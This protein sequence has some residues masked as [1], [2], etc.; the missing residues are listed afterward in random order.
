VLGGIFVGLVLLAGL[1]LADV[2]ATVFFA[3]TVAYLLA[4]VDRW[5]R[6][7]GLSRRRSSL[8]TAVGAFVGTL[9]LFSPLIV[10]FALR[11]NDLLVA[12]ETLPDMISV[13]L[14]GATYS[15]TTQQAFEAL[16][17]ILQRS[18]RVAV[19]QA[20]ILLAKFALFVFLVFSLLYHQGD[21]RRAVLAVIP[22]H[23][24]SVADSL[25]Q[26][27][28]DTLFAIYVLQ[29][30]T[31]AGTFLIAVPVFVVLGYTFPVTLAFLAAVL[32]FL[33]VVGPSLLL[34]G[35]AAGHVAFGDPVAAILV[36]LIGGFLIAW[37]PD[38]LIRPRLA[39]ETAGLSGSLYF[40]GFV[41]GLLTL[42]PIGI[43]AGPLAVALVA[44]MATLLST[45]LNRVSVSE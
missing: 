29:A 3:V 15:V 20:P 14:L 43:I 9:A 32:Q 28:R 33:P 41:G 27:A 45:E 19:A 42:G 37:L 18:A 25:D 26:R 22:P 11:L 5:F 39:R 17:Q 38:L 21:T 10:I 7:W 40:I 24:R 44:E 31:A 30:A 23:Y 1:L 12:L 34:L 13:E 2:I 6:T 36:L 16:I 8:V 35:L 4:P